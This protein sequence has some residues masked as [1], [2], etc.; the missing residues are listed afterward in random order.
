MADTAD[1]LHRVQHQLDLLVRARL[2]APLS[3]FE[4]AEYERLTARERELLAKGVMS[5]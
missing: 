2:A 3:S 5:A 1:D 4:L